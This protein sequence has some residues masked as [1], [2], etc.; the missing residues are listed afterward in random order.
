MDNLEQLW[1]PGQPLCILIFTYCY[2]KDKGT[3][4]SYG[5]PALNFTV[6]ERFSLQW[7]SDKEL[8]KIQIK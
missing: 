1:N 8:G 6:H 7:L 2:E 3:P 4:A 5:V